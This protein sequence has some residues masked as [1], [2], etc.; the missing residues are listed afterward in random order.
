MRLLLPLLLAARLAHV[1][2]LVLSAHDDQRLTLGGQGVRDVEGEGDVPALMVAHVLTLDPHAGA[3]VYGAEVQEHTPGLPRLL[4][5]ASQLM[6]P[7]GARVP[8]HRVVRRVPDA[9][10]GTLGREGDRDR[11]VR[12]PGGRKALAHPGAGVVVGET[13]G[14][15]EGEPRGTAQ[16]GEGVAQRGVLVKGGGSHECP[17]GVTEQGLSLE[18][19]RLDRT[20]ATSCGPRGREGWRARRP[21]R[22][23]GSRGAVQPQQFQAGLKDS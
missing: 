21:R 23:R 9:G 2:R 3:V 11:A 17:L 8:H 18:A 4:P 6:R 13:P 16:L 20:P 15:V 19:L 1:Q 14:A 7:Q 12:D 10:Q 5:Q 22:T